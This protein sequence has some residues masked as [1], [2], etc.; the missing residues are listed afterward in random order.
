MKS[1]RIH[2]VKISESSGRNSEELL[3]ALLLSPVKVRRTIPRSPART[4]RSIS[5]M[6]SP[7]R[8]VVSPS[9]VCN[10]PIKHNT[11]TLPLFPEILRD[12]AARKEILSQTAR[13]ALLRVDP[14][15]KEDHLRQVAQDY[16][17][18]PRMAE[19]KYNLTVHS[20]DLR[21]LIF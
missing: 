6:L 18:N 12:R 5:N 15:A 20:A 4:R 16:A 11:Q 8:L 19:S 10:N 21:E 9:R 7:V 2:R 3:K 14:T 13:S 1:D 17:H